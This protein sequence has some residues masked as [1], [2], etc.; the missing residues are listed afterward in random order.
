MQTQAPAPVRHRSPFV[1]AF[2][3][4]LFPGLGQAYTGFVLRGLVLAAP[5]ILLLALLAGVLATRSTRD[6]LLAQ[7]TSPTVLLLVL[8]ANVLLLAYRLLVIVDAFRLAALVE[9]AA[10]APVGRLSRARLSFSPLA[11]VGLLAILVVTPVLHVSAARYNVLAYQFVTGISGSEQ[12]DGE[13]PTDTPGPSG[14]ATLTPGASGTQQPLPQWNGK[15]RL[16]I[17]LVGVDQRQGE[18]TFNT[19]TMIVASI[20]P[21]SKQVAMLSLPRDME[22]IPLPAS[23]PAHAYYANGLY[24]AKIN[25][26]WSRAA[27][28]PGLFPF[29]GNRI[30]RGYQALKGALGAL[31][32]LNIQYY[33]SVNFEG[34]QKAVDELG[35]VTIDVQMPVTDDHMPIPDSRAVNLYIPAGIQHL[36][37]QAAL[38]Y[39]R[40]RH[41]SNDFDRAQ[42]QQRVILSLREQTDLR[43]LL[44]F[45]RLERLTADLKDAVHTDIPAD[46]FPQLMGLGES[47]DLGHL[48]S[49]VFT[50]PRYAIECANPAAACFYSLTAR[51][52][53]IRQAV[54]N[55][56]NISPQLEA[57]WLKLAAEG[58][59]VEVINGSGVAGQASNVADWLQYLGFDAEVSTINGG[60]ADRLDYQQTVV[61]VYN[62]AAA[63]LPETI[64]VLEAQFGV[65]VLTKSD[66][67]IAT[68]DFVLVTT[69]KLTPKFTVP[70]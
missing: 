12:G 33:V 8:V 28:A 70:Q 55:A 25:S 42:R 62:G 18:A 4:F 51:V 54:K 3:S 20:D 57:S 31:Y 5:M 30:N 47:L 1:A 67:G 10:V 40:A 45:G 56:F 50:P 21:V 16:N 65:T 52:P 22:G 37:G 59:T 2:L 66:P 46:L 24:P 53:Q 9:G 39:A 14:T 6:A 34:F 7:L 49:L 60:R 36:D 68:K 23:W 58:A 13:G 35:G 38:A 64:R 69:G 17:L 26:L 43:S 15:D 61:T 41:T 63:D 32:Q 48:H 19:D 27:G 11:L 29:P 44:D